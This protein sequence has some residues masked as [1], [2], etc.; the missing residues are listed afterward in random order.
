MLRL[1]GKRNV[2]RVLNHAVRRECTG[3][4]GGTA[5]HILGNCT[6][7]TGFVNLSCLNPT[8]NAPLKIKEKVSS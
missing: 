5:P 2:V 3:G 1:E 8:N 4:S 6:R 7:R